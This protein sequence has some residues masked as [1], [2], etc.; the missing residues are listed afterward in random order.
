MKQIKMLNYSMD[1]A[2]S[3]KY[4]KVI[5]QTLEPR[6]FNEKVE[7]LHNKKNQIKPQL[8]H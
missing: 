1:F 3:N 4:L 7:V 5:I 8:S 6:I 2:L